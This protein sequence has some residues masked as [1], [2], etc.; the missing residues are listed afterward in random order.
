M[1]VII[2][3]GGQGTRMGGVDKAR[4]T[5]NG[6]P[7]LQILA[8]ELVGHEIVVVSPHAI[9]GFRVVSENPPLGGPVAGIV[10]GLHA[11][12]RP[13]D[14]IGVLAVDAPYSARML[15]RLEKALVDA[16]V[17]G[18]AGVSVTVADDG[19]L[20]PLCAVWREQSLRECLHRLGDPRDRPVKALLTHAQQ[21]VKVLGD[22]SEKDYDTV[23]ELQVLGNVTLPDA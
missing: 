13:E 4:I 22:G 18:M 14:F 6:T 2:L 8:S 10:A 21:I 23:A 9:D 3:A 15:P 20:Q 12:D 1:K 17:A 11:L 7:L 19:R 5:L 16:P